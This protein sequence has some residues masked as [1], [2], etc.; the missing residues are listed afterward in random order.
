MIQPKY[1][2]LY[3]EVIPRSENKIKEDKPLDAAVDKL[4]KIRI[5]VD[6]ERKEREWKRK[7]T[8]CKRLE[9]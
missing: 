6:K 2:C 7:R 5:N 8:V 1:V 4:K 3:D 9:R